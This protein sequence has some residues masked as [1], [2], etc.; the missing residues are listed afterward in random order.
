[1]LQRQKALQDAVEGTKIETTTLGP[2]TNT[3]S[4][5]QTL[6]MNIHKGIF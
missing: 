5:C 1:M 6:R 2:R 4:G 3:V